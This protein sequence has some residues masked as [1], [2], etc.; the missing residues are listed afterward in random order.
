MCTQYF[1]E[2]LMGKDDLTDPRGIWEANS[3]TYLRKIGHGVR[4]G[5]KLRRNGVGSLI[6]F[7]TLL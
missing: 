4:T 6:L 2:K 7:W 3:K 1:P 5:I